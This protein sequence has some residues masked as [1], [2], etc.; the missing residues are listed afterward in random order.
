MILE[1]GLL[2]WLAVALLAAAV[3]ARRA[4]R[5]EPVVAD[6]ILDRTGGAQ[7]ARERLALGRGVDR[8]RLA[9]LPLERTDARRVD[10]FVWR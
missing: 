1:L 7:R 6:E 8:E 4:S 10:G 3:P 2:K 9:R 5:V